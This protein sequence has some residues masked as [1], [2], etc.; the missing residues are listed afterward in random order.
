[1]D[2][3]NE[4]EDFFGVFS[5]DYMNFLNIIR[6]LDIITINPPD[7]SYDINHFLS[8]FPNDVSYY[9]STFINSINS[10]ISE[11]LSTLNNVFDVINQFNM[12]L[13]NI[14][15][16]QYNPPIIQ[17]RKY[18]S[19]VYDKISITYNKIEDKIYTSIK[20]HLFIL[21]I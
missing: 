13:N 2:F 8:I 16:Y 21:V 15:N 18:I 6:D 20:Y 12:S 9:Y 10:Y 19:N 3:I 11:H 5:I 17:S 4:I 7:F 14:L 1:M